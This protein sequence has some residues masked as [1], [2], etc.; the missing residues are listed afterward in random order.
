MLQLT[1]LLLSIPLMM[2]LVPRL[3]IVGAALALLLSTTTRFAMAVMSFPLVLKVPSPAVLPRKSDVE[4]LVS[5]TLRRFY[6]FR[7]VL[8]N[9][10]RAES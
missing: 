3:G 9:A 5:E 2:V 6:S 8:T 4:Y 10:R 1:G 7:H